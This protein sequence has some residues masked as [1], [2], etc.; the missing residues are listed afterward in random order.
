MLSVVCLQLAKIDLNGS[1][2]EADPVVVICYF[3]V[4]LSSLPFG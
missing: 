1:R 2:I 4:F 3:M